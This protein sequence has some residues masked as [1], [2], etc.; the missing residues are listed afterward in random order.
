MVKKK[1]MLADSDE[2]F[3]KELTYYFMEHVSRFELMTFTKKEKMYQYLEQG[4]KTDIL[5]VDWTF[6]EARL[7][8]LTP[9]T[10]RLAMSVDMAPIEGF[11]LVK[12]Y[13]RMEALSDAVLLKYAEDR[14]TLD[15]VRGDSSTRIVVF[16]SPAGGTGKTTMALSLAVAGAKSGLRTLYL[17]LEEIDS[18]KDMLGRTPGN[19]SDV[20][21][22]LKTK[23][24]NIG[25]KVK[26][27]IGVE[28]MAGFSYIS[29]VDS[30]SEYEEINGNDVKRLLKALRELAAYDL[31]V[32]D[33]SS[34]FGD[35]TKKILEEADSILVP[36]TFEEGSIAKMQR[37][38]DESRLH[39]IYEPFFNKMGIIQNK[40]GAGGLGIGR[41]P[42]SIGGRIPCF[43]NIAMLPVLASRGDILRS[44]ERIMQIMGPV[45][46]ATVGSKSV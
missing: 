19:L 12:K 34:G 30:V 41:I 13:Q 21:L 46:Q 29:G 40:I 28:P 5:L 23:G 26:G 38:L 16:Y 35:K 3:I 9:D 2:R 36:M 39:D 10:T 43:A 37:F 7:R 42:D 15:T 25:I 18:V 45:L 4:N 44:G 27:C 17:N 11:E 22:A 6:A 31:V 33:Q 20:F 8:E 32:V 14:D 1:I 24:M